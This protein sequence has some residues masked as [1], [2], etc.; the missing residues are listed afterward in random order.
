M[1]GHAKSLDRPS[2]KLDCP[3]GRS[4]V[5]TS[6]IPT[7]LCLCGSS[8]P[9]EPSCKDTERHHQLTEHHQEGKVHILLW[10]INLQYFLHFSICLS[11]TFLALA[12]LLWSPY[13]RGAGQRWGQLA[14]LQRLISWPITRGRRLRRFS[15]GNDSTPST[16]LLLFYF[17]THHADIPAGVEVQRWRA[18]LNHSVGR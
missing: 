3:S 17:D 16:G 5:L 10:P 14:G 15:I 6:F 13:R 18:G 1:K 9:G 11:V 12:C 2:L 8:L 4:C 7:G